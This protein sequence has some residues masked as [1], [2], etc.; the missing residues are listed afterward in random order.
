MAKQIVIAF[1]G[2]DGSGKTVQ[3][4]R[5]E[6]ALKARGK[7][8]LT[9]SFPAYKSFFGERI[10]SLLSG[11]AGV[12]ADQVDAKSMALWF[13]MDRWADFQDRDTS[14]ADVLLINRYVLS[15][16]VYQ[17]IRERDLSEPD[18]LDWVNELEYKRLALPEPD[19][20]L[21]LDVQPNDAGRNVD[22]KGFREYVGEARDVYES[23]GGIQARAR[24]KY[25]EYAKRCRNI[26]VVDCMEQGSLLPEDEVFNRIESALSECGV[27]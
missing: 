27:L 7:S 11:A 4:Q 10:G 18:I 14:N 2:I 21:V 23:A 3:M 8:V 24:E 13:A 9:R 17:S 19:V 5:L 25:L 20:H 1:E 12:R 26:V 15:N 6:N 22:K 16:A